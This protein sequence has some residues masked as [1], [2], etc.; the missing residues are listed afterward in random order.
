MRVSLDRIVSPLVGTTTEAQQESGSH[1]V[2]T[3]SV[4][5]HRS[6]EVLRN[7]GYQDFGTRVDGVVTNMRMERCS[8]A[9]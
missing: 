9:H 3:I 2:R 6:R 4:V 7:R 5:A 1:M 8:I